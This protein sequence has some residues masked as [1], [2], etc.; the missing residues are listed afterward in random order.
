MELREYLFRKR[1]TI[2]DFS[3]KIGVSR[4]YLNR[5]VNKWRTPSPKLAKKIEEATKGEV[6]KEELLFPEDFTSQ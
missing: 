1:I 6:T 4:H 3:K 2:T 5:I